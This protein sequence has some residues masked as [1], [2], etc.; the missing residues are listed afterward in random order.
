[1]GNLSNNSRRTTILI[2]SVIFLSHIN[3]MLIWICE[4]DDMFST[5]VNFTLQSVILGV[6]MAY[7]WKSKF[8]SMRIWGLSYCIANTLLVLFLNNYL[9]I[10]VVYSLQDNLPIYKNPIYGDTLGF[11][12]FLLMCFLFLQVGISFVIAHYDSKNDLKSKNNRYYFIAIIIC[13]LLGLTF[14]PIA[15]RVFP[16]PYNIRYIP[17]LKTYVTWNITDSGLRVKFSDEPTFKNPCMMDLKLDNDNKYVLINV[18]D[19]RVIGIDSIEC[20]VVST[21]KYKINNYHNSPEKSEQWN[22]L[23]FR[24]NNFCFKYCYLCKSIAIRNPNVWLP[25]EIPFPY[26]H[27]AFLSSFY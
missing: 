13:F 21:G 27:E 2:A 20:N 23:F 14:Q 17:R 10:S 19:N 11:L 5:M 3:S 7:L 1:M 15:I 4:S 25:F 9:L 12:C 26:E 22:T 18:Y 16:D 8:F 24:R 6:V